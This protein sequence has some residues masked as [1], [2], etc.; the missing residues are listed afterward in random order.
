MRLI[1]WRLSIRMAKVWNRLDLNQRRA[2]RAVRPVLYQLS[3][4][5]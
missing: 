1:S 3:Y 2:E 4:D 5:P